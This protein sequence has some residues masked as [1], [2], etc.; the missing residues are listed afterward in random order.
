[1]LQYFYI[2]KPSGQGIF[3]FFACVTVSKT[4]VIVNGWKPQICIMS[5]YLMGWF[6]VVSFERICEMFSHVSIEMCGK[7]GCLGF[8]T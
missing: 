6:A 8:S 5:H 3:L 2:S 7:R 1:L 4:S